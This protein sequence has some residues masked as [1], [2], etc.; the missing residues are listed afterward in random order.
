MC[1][2]EGE[3]A[4]YST[5]KHTQTGQPPPALTVYCI[6]VYLSLDC[7]CILLP[8]VLSNRMWHIP[9]NVYSV[10]A[11]NVFILVFD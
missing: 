8:Q 7:A 6:K 1:T 4:A 2:C 9:Q 10:V 11:R 5:H 3:A